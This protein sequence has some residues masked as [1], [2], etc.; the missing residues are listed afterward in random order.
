MRIKWGII[1]E[2]RHFVK[3]T[4]I[5]HVSLPDLDELID[6]GL[7]VVSIESSY[8]RSVGAITNTAKPLDPAGDYPSW[9]LLCQKTVPGKSVEFS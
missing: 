4:R 9:R 2:S 5:V 6:A 8:E 7:T 3:L 1:G